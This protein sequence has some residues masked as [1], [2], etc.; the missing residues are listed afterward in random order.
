MIKFAFRYSESGQ[1]GKLRRLYGRA[2]AF[3][4]LGAVAAGIV[5]AA[6]AALGDRIFGTSGLTVPLLIAAAL[7]LAQAPESVAGAAFVLRSRYDIRSAFLLV[8]MLFRLAGFAV[9]SRSGVAETVAG[10]L[11]AQVV[12]SSL[13]GSAA[14][15]LFRR[16][17]RA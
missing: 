4:G 3:K 7:P 2:L 17:P 5:L 12:A 6:G 10:V 11:A 13:V 14:L 15:R 8:S 9:G 1:W 16:F